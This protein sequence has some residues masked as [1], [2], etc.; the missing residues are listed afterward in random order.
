MSTDRDQFVDERDLTDPDP[1]GI[2][3]DDFVARSSAS[4]IRGALREAEQQ[5]SRDPNALPR[6]PESGCGSVQ[7]VR[8]RSARTMPHK[9]DTAYKC[10]ACGA[11]FDDPRP[12][13]E[14]SMPGEQADLGDVKR[15]VSRR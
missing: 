1:Y 8:K 14:D 12:S 2:V 3:P 11:H 4:T 9:V 6:C 7:L 13:I 10:K 5:T 15:E